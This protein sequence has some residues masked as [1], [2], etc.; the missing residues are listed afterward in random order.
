VT[1]LHTDIV[2]VGA[3]AAGAAAALEIDDAGG[4]FIGLDRLDAFGG[5]AAT[6]GGG[7]CIGG[8]STQAAWAI[9]DSP[10]LALRDHLAAG[11]GE[12]DEA[13][14]RFYFDRAVVEVHDWVLANGVE[15]VDVHGDEHSAVPRWHG[16]KGSG[17]GLM[18]ALFGAL[19]ARGIADR[20]RFGSVVEELLTDDDGRVVGV[21][22]REGGGA[23]GATGGHSGASGQ[24]LEIRARAVVMATGGF[25]GDAEMVLL[26][27]PALREA[28]HVLIGGGVGATGLGHV[29]V[30]AHGAELGHLGNMWIYAFAT[31]DPRDPDGRRGLVMRGMDSAIWVNRA[32]RRF[33]DESRPGP[34]SATPALLAQEGSTC[35]AILDRAMLSRTRIAD[36]AFR[37]DDAHRIAA[38]EALMSTS[39][40][41]AVADSPEELASLAGIE[42][43][44]FEETFHAWDVLLAS[45]VAVD[46]LTGRALEGVEGYGGP[47]YYA[48]KFHPL[49]RKNL[50]GVSTDLR[51]RVL[52]PGGA[53]IAGL[54]AAGELAGFGGGH[55]AGRRA[56][57]GIMIGAS[58]FS[59]R[60]AG[61]WAA[62]ELGFP[63]PTHLDAQA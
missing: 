18:D 27:S 30:A 4:S 38:I 19:Q 32:G 25:A 62:H 48:I 46:P 39:P 40:A 50:G 24:R 10:E 6:S 3:G 53:P 55:L 47:P 12:A 60:V 26:Q 1:V 59:G 57:E 33:V 31:P 34:G 29:L 43:V 5:T 42:P 61:G 8:T 58:L 2:I 35:W 11:D 44:G 51:G 63:R 16:P 22:A 23:G 20:W 36:A 56:L 15:F 45:G 7:I 13:W 9:E 17:R 52:T 21:V 41:I 28:E 37:G 14:S 49:A 54:Y